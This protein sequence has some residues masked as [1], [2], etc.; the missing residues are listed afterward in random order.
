MGWLLSNITVGKHH[1]PTQYQEIKR[2]GWKSKIGTFA[3][4]ENL[5]TI[6]EFVK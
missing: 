6:R 2:K 3:R 1:V 4:S 5:K